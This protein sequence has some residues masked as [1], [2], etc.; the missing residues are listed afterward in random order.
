MSD[1]FD[2]VLCGPSQHAPVDRWNDLINQVAPPFGVPPNL[3]KAHMEYESDGDPTIVGSSGR[4]LGL[5]QIDYGTAQDGTGRWY[6]S[7]AHGK[8]YDIFDPQINI[9]IACRDF[10]QPAMAAFPANLDAVIAAYNA[11]IDVVATACSSGGDLTTVTFR[12][13]Y[14]PSVRNAF[15]FFNGLSHGI[16]A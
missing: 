1:I 9:M 3:V 2:I 12:P 7:S 13:W 11:G 16:A 4:G 6:Y 14:I 10:I 15:S 8:T 5:M